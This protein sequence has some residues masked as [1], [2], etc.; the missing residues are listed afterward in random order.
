LPAWNIYRLIESIAHFGTE[1]ALG[2]RKNRW[3]MLMAGTDGKMRILK[4]PDRGNLPVQAFPEPGQK[5]KHGCSL[6]MVEFPNGSKVFLDSRGL[7]HFKSSDPNLPEVS[8]V[9]ADGEVAGWTS[10][11]HVCGPSFFFAGQNSFDPPGVFKRLMNI[12][13]SS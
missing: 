12:S 8:L 7:L 1:V 6:R 10:D 3:W 2:G 5:I 9:L 13:A 11:G 4:V